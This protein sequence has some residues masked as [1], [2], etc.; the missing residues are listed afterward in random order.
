[1]PPFSVLRL[2]HAVLRVRDVD[3]AIAFWRDVLGCAVARRRDELGLVHLRAGASLVDL[4][5]VDGPL[6]REGGAAP[7]DGGR[8]LD[9]VCLRV[10]PFDAGAIVAHLAAHGI[11]PRAPVR[12]VFGAEGDGPSLYVSD[13]EGNTV[14]LKGP[15]AAAADREPASRLSG[16]F[17]HL[18]DDGRADAVPAGPTF[19]AELSA[20]GHPALQQGGRLVSAFDFD[21]PWTAWERHPAG[22][23]LVMLM[24]GE[25][26]LLLET[27]DGIRT[28]RLAEPGDH[29]LVPAGV[30]HTA[31]TD[32]PTRL[33]F[34][35]PG[36]GTEHRVG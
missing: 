22:E 20:G 18:R 21:A 30:W 1:M 6:G 26:D 8:N 19:W 2:D 29:V 27:A 33:L 32:R 5:A 3:G 16:S 10:E 12:T 23:E 13:P 15:P 4:V 17:V 7:G 34:V 9:H 28:V 36:A 35:T 24:S 31:R 11:A 25:A 14:E